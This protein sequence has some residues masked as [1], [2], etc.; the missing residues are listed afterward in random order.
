[1]PND[2]ITACLK[3]LG[4]LFNPPAV[5]AFTAEEFVAYAEA[6]KAAAEK[7]S[8]EAQIARITALKDAAAKADAAFNAEKPAEKIEFAPFAEPAAPVATPEPPKPEDAE[9]GAKMCPTCKKPMEHTGGGAYTCKGCGGKFIPAKKDDEQPVTPPVVPVTAPP[10][11]A[12]VAQAA[13]PTPDAW[14]GVVDLAAEVKKA[15]SERK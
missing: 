3:G 9:K 7:E 10:A 1:M 2:K 13:P 8:G 11:Q 14:S 12:P 4:T 6:Q 15:A 5:K